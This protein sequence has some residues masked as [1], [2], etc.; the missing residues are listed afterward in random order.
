MRP[1]ILLLLTLSTSV[2]AKEKAPP[3]KAGPAALPERIEKTKF[4]ELRLLLTEIQRS[5]A[6]IELGR[7]I[8]EEKKQSYAKMSAALQQE[9]KFSVDA[10]EVDKDGVITRAPSKKPPQ[11]KP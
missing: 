5:E 9:F 7:R 4:L 6:Q 8:L 10:D 2:H 3:P 1:V 11:E